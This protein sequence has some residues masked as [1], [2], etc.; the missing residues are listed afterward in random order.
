MENRA[1]ALAAGL[2]TLL[3]GAGVLVAAMWFSGETYER[4]A[5][6][7]ESRYA[8]TGLNIQAPVRLRGVEVGKV[9]SIEFDAEDRR[10]ILI[11]IG[12]RSGTP[13]TRGTVAQLGSQGVTGLSYVM[14]EDDGTRPEPLQPSTDKAAR[15]PVRQA[16]FDE[17]TGSGKDLITEVHHV[18]RRLN[19][20]LDDRNQQQLM[21]TLAML[22]SATARITTLAQAVESGVQGLPALTADA[23]KTLQQADALMSGLENLTRQLAQRVDTLE[24]VAKSAEQVAGSAQSVS[25]SVDGEVLPRINVLVDELARNSRS[26]ERLLTELNDQPHSLVFGRP[27]AASGPGEP[28]FNPQPGSSRK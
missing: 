14:L 18:A 15:I 12:V 5:Y 24:R 3:L 4:V 17:L 21:R 1:Y 8:V 19:V 16:F 6:V 28:G 10:H 26:L 27:P 20:L 11:G 23:R 25:A 2:F 7:L 22:E 13:I 9:E